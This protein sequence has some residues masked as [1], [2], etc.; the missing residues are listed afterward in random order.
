MSG[1]WLC[2]PTPPSSVFLTPHDLR[3]E[4]NDV[5]SRP[6]SCTVHTIKKRE[7]QEADESPI[8]ILSL[9]GVLAIRVQCVK[10]SRVD[11]VSG[12]D[13]NVSSAHLIPLSNRCSPR[14]SSK[15]LMILAIVLLAADGLSVVVVDS[16]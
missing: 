12:L 6:F 3:L 7:P 10:T 8:S 16:M 5:K 11:I 14:K 9:H 4:Q 13:E 2:A 1:E 15:M